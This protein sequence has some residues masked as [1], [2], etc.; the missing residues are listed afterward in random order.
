[1]RLRNGF[2][3]GGSSSS[4]LSFCLSVK[5][6]TGQIEQFQHDKNVCYDMTKEVP[7]AMLANGDRVM[8]VKI[9][10]PNKQVT[11]ATYTCKSTVHPI[12][13]VCSFCVDLY[14]VLAHDFLVNS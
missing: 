3:F 12:P 9:C 11:I 6:S 7:N 13:L 10:E 1:V 8:R 4:S 2:V 14:I 5:D